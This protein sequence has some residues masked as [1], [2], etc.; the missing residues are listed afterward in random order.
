MESI[1]REIPPIKRLIIPSIFIVSLYFFQMQRGQ[2]TQQKWSIQGS[3]MGTTYTVQVVAPKA[4]NAED[5]QALLDK[6]NQ[7]MS[8]YIQESELNQLNRSPADQTFQASDALHHVLQASMKV[9]KES[10]GA[11]DITI[12]PLVN[13]WGF[14]PD[15]KRKS[16]STE[17]IKAL[18]PTIGS[19]L[20]Q[21]KQQK[22]SKQRADLYCDLSAIAKGYAVDQVS[23]FLSQHQFNNHWVEIGGEVKT[24]GYN[25]Q[26]K[27]WRVGVERP[28]KQQR[29][30]IYQIIPLWNMSMATSGDYRNHYV[31]E[32][33]IERSHTIDPRTG[34]PITH[35]LASVSVLHAENMY[36]DAWAT[37]LNVLGIEAGLKIANQYQL[38]AFFIS[39]HEKEGTIHFTHHLS[40]ALE[41]YLTQQKVTLAKTKH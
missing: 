5:I 30:A 1:V 8:T 23:H 34:M 2:N 13:A 9:Y 40:Q 33:G 35:T 26:G 29:R 20:L 3:I 15:K 16:P 18:L 36:A 31:D 10:Q 6:I 27:A 32:Q 12:G 17:Q 38:A 28:A 24:K 22:W 19:H 11:F 39:K 25:A 7:K 14:G 37:A 4:P 21:V 41:H